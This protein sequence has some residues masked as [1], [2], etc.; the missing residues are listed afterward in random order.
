MS[1]GEASDGGEDQDV[2]VW[3]DAEEEDIDK[4]IMMMAGAVTPKSEVP[5]GDA[6]AA[7][8]TPGPD[9]AAEMRLTKAALMQCIA[10]PE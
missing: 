8:A 10:S 7:S 2:D 4:E 6:A 1:D 5:H 3:H 9:I